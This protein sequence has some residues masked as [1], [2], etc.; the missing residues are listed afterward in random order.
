M[1]W[2]LSIC[3]PLTLHIY[4]EMYQML[5]D[6]KELIVF[7]HIN[8]IP[9]PVNDNEFAIR[10]LILRSIYNNFNLIMPTRN[11]ANLVQSWMH[12]DNKRINDFFRDHTQVQPLPQKS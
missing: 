11:P 7:G 8:Y 5:L 2:G 3:I 12:Y 10:K 9:N 4:H 6:S 1:H